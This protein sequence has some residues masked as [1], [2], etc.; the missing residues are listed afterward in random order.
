[1]EFFSPVQKKYLQRYY[2]EHQNAMLT[3]FQ[4]CHVETCTIVLYDLV[5][6]APLGE[7]N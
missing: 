3:A 4:I 6:W 1:M 5:V 2:L 7:I